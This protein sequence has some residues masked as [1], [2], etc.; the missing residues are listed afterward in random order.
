MEE[1]PHIFGCM[2]RG[3]RVLIGHLSLC[4][5]MKRW[6]SHFHVHKKRKLNKKCTTLTAKISLNENKPDYSGSLFD[7]NILDKPPVIFKL[8]IF[9]S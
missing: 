9:I 3:Q 2:V 6:K 8:N 1:S 5:A 7:Y 4:T